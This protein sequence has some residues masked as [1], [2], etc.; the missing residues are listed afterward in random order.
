MFWSLG[1]LPFPPLAPSRTKFDHHHLFTDWA[2]Y[3]RAVLTTGIAPAQTKATENVTSPKQ[4]H[5]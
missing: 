3:Q 5:R 1:H 4:P 2:T